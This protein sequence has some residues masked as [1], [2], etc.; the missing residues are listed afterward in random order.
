MRTR[1][2]LLV[3]AA[4]VIAAAQATAF[5]FL[6]HDTFLP[7]PPRLTQ[8][9]FDLAGWRSVAD[10]TINPDSLAM[11][12]PD[13][14]L[15]RVYQ[16]AEP[17]RKAELF[18]AYYKTQ[19]RAKNAHDPKVCLPGSGWNP[20]DSHVSYVSLPSDRRPFPA[21]YYLIEKDGTKQVVLYWFQTLRG[22]YTHEQQLRLQ[23]I[24]DAIQINRTDVALV[25]ISV[26]VTASGLQAAGASAVALARDAYMQMIPYFP[27]EHRS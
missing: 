1:K 12:S 2:E 16:S 3:M 13:D 18:I 7:S 6:R 9:S 19:L 14:Y 21:N 22:A 11:L 27:P 15:A 20:L 4:L 25:R 17:G 23:R 10:E 5:W 8:F 24:I 26:P